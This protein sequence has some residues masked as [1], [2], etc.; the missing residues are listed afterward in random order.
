MLGTKR[1]PSGCLYTVIDL[2]HLGFDGQI[3]RYDSPGL[4]SSPVPPAAAHVLVH[5]APDRSEGGLTGR[6]AAS[7]LLH[8]A[9]GEINPLPVCASVCL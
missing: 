1:H 9:A 5:S 2:R 8:R 7:A 3:A 4:I 6:C